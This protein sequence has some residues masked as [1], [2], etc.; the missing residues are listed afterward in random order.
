MAPPIHPLGKEKR[1]MIRFLSEDIVAN[2]ERCRLTAVSEWVA[3]KSALQQSLLQ[4]IEGDAL[5]DIAA[6]S[7]RGEVDAY[8]HAAATTCYLSSHPSDSESNSTTADAIGY[9]EF[10]EVGASDMDGMYTL[11][12]DFY[13]TSNFTTT[14]PLNVC[15]ND[16]YVSPGGVPGCISGASWITEIGQLSQRHVCENEWFGIDNAWNNLRVCAATALVGKQEGTNVTR[17]MEMMAA[18]QDQQLTTADC[19]E[20]AC[21]E[22]LITDANKM[23]NK[24]SSSSNQPMCWIWIGLLHGALVWRNGAVL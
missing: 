19:A 6:S 24:N 12:W 20:E 8:N 14:P 11:A 4:I 17:G 21:E 5:F 18:F 9:T 1:E 2:A 15:S 10:W 3:S 22:F 7:C 13:A 16:C 23:G